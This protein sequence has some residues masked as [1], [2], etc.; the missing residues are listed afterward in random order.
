MYST[1]RK[2][3]LITSS[4]QKKGKSWIINNLA[5]AFAQANKKVILVDTDLRKE[6][7][8]NEIFSVDKG[9]GLSDFIKEISNNK[10]ENLEK[11]KNT[12]KKLNFQIY[13]YYKMEQY[14]LI[15]QNYYHLII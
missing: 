1:N 8:K 9:E 10:L 11:S 15:H 5:I 3:I 14:H 7:E 12:L 13:I 4:K 2:T 6:N